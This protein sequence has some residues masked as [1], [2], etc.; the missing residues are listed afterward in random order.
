[1]GAGLRTTV[2]GLGPMVMRLRM[3]AAI[4]EDRV[5]AERPST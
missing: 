5:A 4:Y 1:M 3:L 2:V